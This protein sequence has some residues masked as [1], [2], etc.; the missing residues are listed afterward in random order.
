[1]TKVELKSRVGSDGVLNVSV[2]LGP[3]EANCDV[4]ITIQRV[5]DIGPKPAVSREEWLRFIEETAG[6]WQG[7]P[8]VRPGQGEFEQRQK[9]A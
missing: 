8:F 3:S 2:P 7:E 5:E 1:M 6:R 4:K 9:W